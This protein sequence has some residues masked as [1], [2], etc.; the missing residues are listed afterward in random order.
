MQK[1]VGR[2]KKVDLESLR[3]VEKRRGGSK[4]VVR[5]KEKLEFVKF[6]GNGETCERERK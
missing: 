6:E 1:E 4:V 5:R 2:R 3:D